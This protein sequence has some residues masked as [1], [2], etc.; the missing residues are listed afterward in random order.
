M[1]HV[2]IIPAATA[3][4]LTSLF[5]RNGCV[6]RQ[7]TARCEAEGWT[8]YKKGDEIRLIA[9]TNAERDRVMRLLKRADFKAGRP[10]LKHRR[11][12]SSCVPIYGREQV[13][14]FLTMVAE[15]EER[16]R[17]PVRRVATRR[18]T[19]EKSSGQRC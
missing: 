19:R 13:A 8:K 7:N 1:N 17:T 2:K 4:T 10:F 9:N 15:T 16:Q 18:K 14:R 11:P 12:G 6:R 5:R 3:R